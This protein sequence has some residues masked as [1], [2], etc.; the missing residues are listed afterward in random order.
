MP[1]GDH[2]RRFGVFEV[3]LAAGELRRNGVRVKLQDQPFQVLAALLERPGQ[4]V[5]KEE[6]QE[7]IWKD[8][9]FVDFDRSLATAVNKVRQALGDSATNSRFV[10]TVPKRGYR[11]VGEASAAEMGREGQKRAPRFR[12]ATL[13]LAV[14]IV[15]VAAAA[16]WTS[17][18]NEPP[19]VPLSAEPLTAY[20]GTEQDPSISPDGSRVAFSWRKS[21]SNQSDIFVKLIGAGEP[22]QL[23]TDSA[24]DHDPQWSPDGRYI[25]FARDA[26]D[27]RQEIIR[28]PAQGGRETALSSYLSLAGLGG[29]RVR[30]FCWTPD[31]EGLIISDAEAEGE[32]VGLFLESL[33][34]GART[35]LTDPG[36]G[37][38]L[39][40]EPSIAES[41]VLA[42]LRRR[43]D[44]AQ[45]IYRWALGDV[46]AP[47]GE[48]S[49]VASLPY[50]LNSPMISPSGREIIFSARAPVAALWRAYADSEQP[51]QRLLGAGDRGMESAFSADGR[52]LVYSTW[53]WTWD[54]WRLD[55]DR[56]GSAAG[57]PRRF[58]S[59][60]YD[61][62][63]L[64]YSPNMSQVAF[65]SQ[66]TGSQQVWIADADG[67][68]AEQ[69]TDID[70]SFTGSPSWS[71]DGLQLAFDT[72]VERTWAV[73][74]TNANGS[75]RRRLSDQSLS[76]VKPLWSR[77][78]QWVY[79]AGRQ[80]QDRGVW[81]I[82]AKGGEPERLYASP[83]ASGY[84]LGTEERYLYIGHR[85]RTVWRVDLTT[86]EE[87]QVL[88]ESVASFAVAK[89]GIYFAPNAPM[90]EPGDIRFYR[91]DDQSVSTVE[92]S[93]DFSSHQDESL[94]RRA[95]THIHP[96]SGCE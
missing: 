52:T 29:W 92:C 39:D 65:S 66:R 32:A 68:N 56:P 84:A 58:I 67:G 70:T 3:D 41:G 80:G 14:V 60:T 71:P 78:G 86:G 44:G 21:D 46:S 1:G 72:N 25:A 34:T 76:A 20:P 82:P 13:V 2:I 83:N 55:L 90:L 7:R 75:G 26:G 38:G 54:I 95:R 9:T 4:V 93:S 79:V 33:A 31:G 50:L 15:S 19:P 94:T 12:R 81:R 57:P 77:D 24:Q 69:L 47:R 45:E 89:E 28:V 61:D 17:G 36:P 85:D 8:D 51:P 22:I 63:N 40:I 73:F 6:L 59:S 35:R 18:R 74:V 64:D 11:F 30:R 16:F 62:T 37:F 5:T 42:F 43:P 48:P 87:E 53:H 23:T 96:G 10:E 91:F 49:A 88:S 27:D